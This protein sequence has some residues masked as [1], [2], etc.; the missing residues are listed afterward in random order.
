M[1][2]SQYRLT[3]SAHPRTP[4]AD[5]GFIIAGLEHFSQSLE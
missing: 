4:T 2:L 1:T 5:M 3:A